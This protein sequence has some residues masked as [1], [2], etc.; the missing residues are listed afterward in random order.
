MWQ[1]HVPGILSHMDSRREHQLRT[2]DQRRR[3]AA[4]GRHTCGV[5]IL[6]PP[7]RWHDVGCPHSKMCDTLSPTD[8]HTANVDGWSLLI[9]FCARGMAMRVAGMLET[10]TEYIVTIGVDGGATGSRV[11]SAAVRLSCM[12]VGACLHHAAQHVFS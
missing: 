2:I 3:C 1:Q 9:T 7:G 12:L 4:F 8:A 6:R 11:R 5:D 10:S